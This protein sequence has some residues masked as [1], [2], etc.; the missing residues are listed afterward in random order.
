[1]YLKS[2]IAA[3]LSPVLLLVL[4]HAIGMLPEP[5]GPPL[6]DAVYNAHNMLFNMKEVAVE[7]VTTWS[8]DGQFSC[9]LLHNIIAP[10]HASVTTAR[11]HTLLIL[12]LACRS[13]QGS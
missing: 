2:F 11:K 13:E 12:I 9:V 1:M 5:V 6:Q 4:G 7:E 10:H 3:T 8:L